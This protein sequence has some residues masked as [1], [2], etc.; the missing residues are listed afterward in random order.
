MGVW[1]EIKLGWLKYKA[2]HPNAKTRLAAVRSLSKIED[3]GAVRLL[4]ARLRDADPD[5]WHAAVLAL[6]A[7]GVGRVPGAVDSLGRIAAAPD[8]TTA[9]EA[10]AALGEL[11]RGG[12]L[13]ALKPL[14]ELLGGG[15]NRVAN[16]L[17]AEALG[18][19][20]T[21]DAAMVL[22]GAPLSSGPERERIRQALL[23][24]GEPAVGPIWDFTARH[25]PYSTGG[26]KLSHNTANLLVRVLL[27]VGGDRAKHTVLQMLKPPDRDVLTAA[28]TAL[29]E[30]PADWATEPIIGHLRDAALRENGAFT[31]WATRALGAI[32]SDRAVTALLEMVR[33]E[34]GDLQDGA[35]T[36]L[37]GV[38]RAPP[39]AALL[40][41]ICD[42]NVEVRRISATVLGST[43]SPQASDA[44][45]AA[46]HDPD[47]E[48]RTNAVGSLGSLRARPA[49]EPLLRFLTDPAPGVRAVTVIA[50]G[51]IGDR[52]AVAP[53]LPL[54]RDP[55]G[56]VVDAA[57]GAL[58]SLGEPGAVP[59]L[60]ELADRM[61][62]SPLRFREPLIPGELY[63]GNVILRF[64]TAVALAL[65]GDSRGPEDVASLFLGEVR[66]KKLWVVTELA[67]T[68][69]LWARTILACAV[70]KLREV[71]AENNP[72][73]IEA[74][75]RTLET[76][77]DAAG[78]AVPVQ[79][80]SHL[81]RLSAAYSYMEKNSDGW[82]LGLRSETVDCTAVREKAR[83]LLKRQPSGQMASPPGA[84]GVPHGGPLRCT[85]GATYAFRAE[86][87]G[88]RVKCKRCGKVMM[89]PKT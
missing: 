11:A 56:V 67:R 81:E 82:D 58:G 89:S 86:F 85:C 65:L 27:S 6:R 59:A 12:V 57:V 61:A 79:E 23:A 36:A 68:N 10:L 1:R 24:I 22:L 84:A 50:L 71:V 74:A 37:R 62:T 44:L 66:Q 8:E 15:S 2:E 45:L 39:A 55:D 21:G 13:E 70:P 52:R 72:H 43:G 88:K 25:R 32:A 34:Q 19:V 42:D 31:G 76:I 69:E 28:L 40:A 35:L 64:R 3:P 18:K 63:E 4:T 9:A 54:L 5:V 48:V 38:R 49:V 60:R 16:A 83:S 53:L 77:L 75:L 14:G 47:A 29:Q 78:P 20:G 41:G 80:L 17:A 30:Q 46:L 51:R 26:N 7:L 73:V 87:V 33:N